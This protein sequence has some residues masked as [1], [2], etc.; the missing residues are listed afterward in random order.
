MGKC[1]DNTV[2]GLRMIQCGRQ[3]VHVI[4]PDGQVR[5][6]PLPIK[7]SNLLQLYPHHFLTHASNNTTKQRN[8]TSSG[9][10][11]MLPLDAHLESG[12][13]YILLPLPRLFPALSPPSNE[14]HLCCCACFLPHFQSNSGTGGIGLIK[15]ELKR[16]WLSATTSS[17]KISPEEH[18]A[19]GVARK[20]TAAPCQPRR[21][22]EPAL[23]VISEERALLSTREEEEAAAARREKERKEKAAKVNNNNNNVNN[24]TA[25]TDTT[26]TTTTTTTTSSSS[27]SSSSSK[28]LPGNAAGEQQGSVVFKLGT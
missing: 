10:G 6:F 14:P 19:S 16:H 24:N 18:Y 22:W 20:D 11:P 3:T 17:S 7:V 13:I 28:K 15:S 5:Q 27:S 23:D 4:Q 12:S 1:K 21:L 26:T 25:A 8:T 9:G 2:M